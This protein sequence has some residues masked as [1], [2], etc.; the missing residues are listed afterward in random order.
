M[1]IEGQNLD[2]LKVAA[3]KLFPPTVSSVLFRTD[4]GNCDTASGGE[5]EG[6]GKWFWQVFVRLRE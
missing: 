6:E 5:G 2:G 4:F 1:D 3:L